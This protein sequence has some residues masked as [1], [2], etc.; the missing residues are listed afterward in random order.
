MKICKTEKFDNFGKNFNALSNFLLNQA[1]LIV[2]NSTIPMGKFM[3][4]PEIGKFIKI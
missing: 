1:A 3:K 4:I 2:P